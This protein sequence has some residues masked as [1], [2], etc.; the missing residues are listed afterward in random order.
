MR[1]PLTGAPKNP[2]DYLSL[3]LSRECLKEDLEK[4]VTRKRPKSDSSVIS[5]LGPLLG[6]PFYG[7]VS[8]LG[9][10]FESKRVGTTIACL[11]SSCLVLSCPDLHCSVVDLR[12]EPTRCN[13]TVRF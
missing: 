4:A 1:G 10:N 9:S 3:S 8:L 11:I 5:W 6:I 13:A 7:P 12:C 2:Y